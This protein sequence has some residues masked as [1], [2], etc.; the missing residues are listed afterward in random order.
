MRDIVPVWLNPA[1]SLSRHAEDPRMETGKMIDWN[2]LNG[3]R[4]DIGEEDFADIA[5]IF[6]AEI[7]EYLDRLTANP[8]SATAG[9]FH[10]LRGSAANIGFAAMVEACRSAEAACN[11]GTAPDIAAVAGSFTA[12]LAAIA[13]DIPGIADA[14]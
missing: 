12:S 13:H 6:V 2:R 8:A 9:D 3:L 1:L 11:A 4:A 7:T 14:A 5:F 10:F